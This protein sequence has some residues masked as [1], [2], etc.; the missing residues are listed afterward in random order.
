MK[1][2][3]RELRKSKRLTLKEVA[4]ELN[5]TTD[6]IRKYEVGIRN[7]NIETLCKLADFYDVSLDYL[8]GRKYE[9]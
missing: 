4:N 6:G 3:L 2:R 8:V 5:V 9:N 7:P 1:N